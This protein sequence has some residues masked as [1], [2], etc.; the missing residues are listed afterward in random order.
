MSY[1][2]TRLETIW[3]FK[4]LL[5][6]TFINFSSDST[7]FN[8]SLQNLNFVYNDGHYIWQV[9]ELLAATI[10]AG[11]MLNIFLKLSIASL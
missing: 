1:M 10:F 8:V 6:S 4:F 9:A 3:S 5:G 2:L 7:A 11:F